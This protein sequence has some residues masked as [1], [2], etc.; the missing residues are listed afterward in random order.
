M[1]CITNQASLRISQLGDCFK[2]ID[3][4][5]CGLRDGLNW[6]G[7]QDIQNVATLI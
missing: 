7:I 1:A 6:S 3:Y 5:H 4:E 2:Y